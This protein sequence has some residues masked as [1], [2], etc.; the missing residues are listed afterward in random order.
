MTDDDSS[1]FLMDASD[2]SDALSDG[3]ITMDEAV[4]VASDPQ[5]SPAGYEPLEVNVA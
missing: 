5:D 1:R 4:S 2:L 3:I